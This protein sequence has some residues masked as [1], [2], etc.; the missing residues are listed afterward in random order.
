[1]TITMGS[2][3]FTYEVQPGWAKLP[4]GWNFLEVVDVA[5]HLHPLFGQ[6]R[7]E[8]LLGG[9]AGGVN[10]DAQLPGRG[11]IGL[12]GA[13]RDGESEDRQ[14]DRDCWIA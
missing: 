8:L 2:G 7:Q 6:Q 5:V 12:G 4:A 10:L 3:R 14:Q 11:G 13:G 1:M 9:G